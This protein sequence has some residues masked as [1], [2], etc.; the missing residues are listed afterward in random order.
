[1]NGKLAAIVSLALISWGAALGAAKA[2]PAV[3]PVPEPA[4]VAQGAAAF[5]PGARWLDDKGVHL[6]I[7]GGGL[8][9][10][11]GVY[12]WYGEHKVAGDAGNYA[13]VGVHVYSSK[14]LYNWHDAGVALAVSQDPQS[15]I[16][17]G[18]IIERPKVVY[19]AATRKFVMWFHHELKGKGYSAA[20]AGV[21]VADSPAG[22]FT[23]Q[24]SLR[25]NAGKYPLNMP[26]ELRAEFAKLA[27]EQWAAWGKKRGMEFWARD[28]EGGQMARD[29]NLFMDDDGTAYLLFSSE[30]NGTMHVSRLTKDGLG[31][32]G[33]YVRAFGGYR[34]APAPFKSKGRY[35]MFNSVCS[36]W[37][38]NAARSAVA[39]SIWGPWRELGNPCRGPDAALTFHGQSSYI[40]PVAGQPGTFICYLDRWKQFDLQDSRYLWLPLQLTAAGFEVLWKDSW[41][42]AK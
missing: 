27:K 7:H 9:F 3:P 23:Y 30:E 28:F 26:V 1:M 32:T 20:M 12:Y 17:K 37:A 19:N 11:K 34:E 36:G 8:L 41:K 14:D 40:L 10:H 35:F 5:Q 16:A 18:C 4:L 31:H 39:D 38:P 29:M 42:L 13:Q 21:A 15:P 6:N 2:G 24:S 25:P 22:P 33:E